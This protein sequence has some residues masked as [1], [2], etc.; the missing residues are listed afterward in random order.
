MPLFLTDEYLERLDK[1]KTADDRCR[2][3]CAGIS[4]PANMNYLTG[5]DGWSFYVPQCVVVSL[6]A[7]TPLW[8]GRRMDVAGARHTTFL[9]RIPHHRIPGKLH[10]DPGA[11]SYEFRGRCDCRARLGARRPSASRWMPITSP[12]VP[13]P[14]YRKVCPTHALPTPTCWSTGSGWSNRT[15][16]FHL[17]RE[18]GSDRQPGDDH[19]HRAISNRACANVMPWLPFTRLRCPGRKH[20]VGI[21]RPSCP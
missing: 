12:P 17:M 1:T 10:S 9:S 2:D 13:T 5:Y 16:R 19:G 6:D 8:I 18:A 15:P 14:S 21:I 3:R 11:A 4:D 20:S 7:D